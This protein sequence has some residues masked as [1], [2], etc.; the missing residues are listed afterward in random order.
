MFSRIST[1]VIASALIMFTGCNKTES[2]DGVVFDENVSEPYNTVQLDQTLSALIQRHSL[3]GDPVGDIEVHA[4]SDAKAQLGMKLF[5][6]KSLGGVQDAAC[7]TCHHPVLGGGDNL[8]L[9]IGIEAI[10]SDLLGEGRI[11]DPSGKFYHDGFATVPRNAPTTYNIALWK[12]SLF[13]DGRVENVVNNGVVEGIRTPDTALGVVDVNAGANLAIAQARFPVTSRDEMRSDF[14]TNASNDVVR[15]HIARRLSDTNATDYIANTWSEEFT[16]IY[17]E[18]NITYENIADAIG[19]YERSQVFVNNPW[20]SYVKGDKTAVTDAAKRGAELFFSS[21]GEGGMNCV[22]CHSGDFFS[23]E[24][25]HVMAIPQVGVGK[26]ANGDDLG[27]F[28][29]TGADKYAFRTPS[30]L[31]V[32]MTGPWGHS[33]A[34]TTLRGIVEHNINPDR[35]IENYDVT[36]LNENVITEKMLEHTQKALAQL[37]SNKL[38]TISKHQNIDASDAQVNDIVEFLKALTD[39]CLKERE[40]IG[41]WIPTNEVGPDSLQL[42]A[43]DKDGNLL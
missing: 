1:S 40:C 24:G 29:E 7:V 17:G 10:E 43:I 34:Y 36:Q 31:N 38:A 25:F 16:P 12:R 9:S 8:S 19:E 37:H 21:Y 5:F 28:L 6:T 22:S 18:N 41:K 3:T 35:A 20:N 11:S 32:E 2:K 23:D 42:N 4:I 13:W 27:R 14:E 26:D 15:D 39:P 30:L 33:G